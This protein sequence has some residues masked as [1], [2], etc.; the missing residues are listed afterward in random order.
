MAAAFAI[1][2]SGS[3]VA[4]AAMKW[5]ILGPQMLRLG[6]ARVELLRSTACPA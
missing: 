1:G 4:D 3:A 2:I 6:Y 5:R